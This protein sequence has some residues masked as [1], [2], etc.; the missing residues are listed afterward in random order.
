VADGGLGAPHA[1]RSAGKALFF[2]HSEEGFQ[3]V[4]VHEGAANAG[5]RPIMNAIY[6]NAKNYKFA[7]WGEDLRDWSSTR[8]RSQ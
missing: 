8:H 3:L 5:P 6:V 1:G 4:K 2:D 7:L